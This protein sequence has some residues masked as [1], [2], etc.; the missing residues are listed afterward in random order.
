MIVAAD[1]DSTAYPVYK[2]DVT[3]TWIDPIPGEKQRM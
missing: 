1:G 2:R 3:V